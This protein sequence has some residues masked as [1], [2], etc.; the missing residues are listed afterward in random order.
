[1]RLIP[2]LIIYG[3]I[4]GCD[5]FEVDQSVFITGTGSITILDGGGNATDRLGIIVDEMECYREPTGRE[6]S[7]RRS[8][9]LAGAIRP[10]DLIAVRC[11]WLQ[12][13]ESER[14]VVTADGS[15]LGGLIEMR[16]IGAIDQVDRSAA[17]GRDGYGCSERADHTAAISF[18]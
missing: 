1:M 17:A 3:V 16:R 5:I 10:D 18:G 2:V 8:N 14:G 11:S 15:V 4:T 9:R 7:D 12:A 13:G 6:L